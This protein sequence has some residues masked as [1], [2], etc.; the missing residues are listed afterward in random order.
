MNSS[1]ITISDYQEKSRE[2][3]KDLECKGNLVYPA[4]GF[5]NEAG[6]FLGKLKKVYRD[7]GGDIDEETRIAMGQE[8]GDCLWYFSQLVTNLG[9]TLDELADMNYQKLKSRKERNQIHGNGDN[10]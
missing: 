3:Y 4:L 1:K 8:L 9:F 5:A 10:R 2:T 6:E 7:K